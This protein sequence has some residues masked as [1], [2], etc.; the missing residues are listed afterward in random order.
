MLKLRLGAALVLYQT[1]PMRV[2]LGKRAPHLRSFPGAWTFPGG[3][4]ELQDVQSLERCAL[5]EA[6]EELGLQLPCEGLID[7][8]RRVTPPGNP[9][10]FDTRYFLQHLTDPPPVQPA[11][12]EFSDAQWWEPTELLALW[13]R[14]DASI[15]PPVRDVVSVLAGYPAIT[16]VALGAL[17]ALANDEDHTYP[18]QEMYPGIEAI[19]LRTPTVPPA[20]HTQCYLLGREQFL[21][22]D[23]ASPYPE[24]QAWLDAM[25][26]RR[27]EAGHQPTAIVLT[28]H[29]PDHIGGVAHLHARYGLPVLAHSLTAERVAA[30]F[31]VDQLIEDGHVW[32]LG[33]DGAGRPWQ[34]EA[35]WTPGHAPGHLCLIDQRDRVAIVGDMLAGIGTILIDPKDGHMATYLASLERLAQGQLS[36]AFP[37]HGPVIR[38]VP[39]TC[40]MYIARRQMRE[41]AILSALEARPL[42]LEPLLEE[43]YAD[44]PPEAHSLARQS[45]RAHV[46]KLQEE[47]RLQAPDAQGCYHL[48]VKA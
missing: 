8:G 37:A 15:P 4:L 45:L 47:D 30:H 44:T 17:R 6:E 26:A 27:L 34:V 14:G 13:E 40:T 2:L 1:A 36:L 7:I 48:T 29:H 16:D 43:V 25:L 18:G 39:G 10:R 23:P 21:I 42:P 33:Q 41:R 19:P 5:R 9:V 35:W 46:I 22:V 3:N 32:D 38:D 28:H 12:D 11:P 20:T 24:E 31:P